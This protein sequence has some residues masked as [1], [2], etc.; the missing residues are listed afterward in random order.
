M[1]LRDLLLSWISIGLLIVNIHSQEVFLAMLLL[2]D[3]MKEGARTD[4]PH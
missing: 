2:S 1:Y 3:L 4:I